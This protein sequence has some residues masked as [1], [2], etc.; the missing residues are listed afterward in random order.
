MRLHRA[1]FTAAIA[2]ALVAPAQAQQAD[3][4][5][6]LQWAAPSVPDFAAPQPTSRQVTA[7]EGAENP[8]VTSAAKSTYDRL[9]TG[10]LDRSKLTGDVSQALPAS[11]VQSAAG[12]LGALGTPA[13]SFVGNARSS[14]GDV[15]IYKLQYAKA[16][17]YLTFGVSNA[18]IVYALYLGNKPALTT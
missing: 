9:V 17:A 10:N 6:P 1:I 11:L 8:G 2:L 13:W 7:E 14:A 4:G 15:S 16:V 18:G 3:T 5:Q 12:Q